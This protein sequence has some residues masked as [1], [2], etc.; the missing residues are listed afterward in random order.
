MLKNLSLYL[1]FNWI[2]LIHLQAQ[3]NSNVTNDLREIKNQLVQEE[4]ILFK[5]KSNERNLQKSSDQIVAEITNLA[6]KKQS[7]SETLRQLQFDHSK[8]QAESESIKVEL[9]KQNLLYRERIKAV[10]KMKKRAV[11]LNYLFGSQSLME[12]LRRVK[13]LKDVIEYDK[14]YVQG[15][16]KIISRY[17]DSQK[18]LNNLQQL[19][20][21]SLDQTE[22]VE[23]EYLKKKAEKENLLK[24]EEE[25]I[26]LQEKSIIKLKEKTKE[27]E[28]ILTKIMGGTEK[29][30]SIENTAQEESVQEFLGTGLT[31]LKK[32]LIFPVK[33][34]I[35]QKFGKQK[36]EEYSDILFI[37]GLEISAPIGTRVKSVAAGRIILSQILPAYGNVIIVDHGER[38]Y[39]LYGRLATTLKSVGSFVKAREDL[40]ILGETDYKGRNFY[41]ELRVQGKAIDPLEYFKDPP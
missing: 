38:Y 12:F 26:A 6:K 34:K 40:A 21:K 20:E 5:L 30:S 13:Y 19:K 32:T 3:E 33:G 37:K 35:L 7:I 14:N 1:F 39:S 36:H 2:F 28:K 17:E 18:K 22:K 16:A 11:G 23:A 10:Y 9:E 24:R 15:L 25:R 29:D 8:L 41:F 4:G 27:L 31:K